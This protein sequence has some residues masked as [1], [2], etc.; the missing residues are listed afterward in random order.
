MVFF[1]LSGYILTSIYD[2]RFY[3]G[4]SAFSY[5]DFLCKRI[6]RIY[7]LH[8]FLLIIMLLVYPR[9]V[10]APDSGLRQVFTN[11]T[12]TQAWSF[13]RFSFIA[14]SWSISVE[15]LFYILFPFFV[16]FMRRNISLFVFLGLGLVYG[17]ENNYWIFFDS[18][19]FSDEIIYILKLTNHNI[20]HYGAFFVMGVC[21]YYF[22][23][24]RIFKKLLEN[25]VAF[26]LLVVIVCVS[27]FLGAAK[28]AIAIFALPLLVRSAHTSSLGSYLLGG[29]VIVWLGELSYAIYLSHQLM[30]YLVLSIAGGQVV[31]PLYEWG[32]TYI[33]I[34]IWSVFCYYCI[35]TVA[36][37]R[38]RNSWFASSK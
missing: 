1:A 6:A 25:N 26:L 31:S 12:L 22:S 11:L 24:W 37:D 21:T 3:S 17:F 30:H 20:F 16:F 33:L 35:E 27:S 15:F 8:F 32:S 10:Y 23:D 36:R 19:K 5:F 28:Y 13:D 38:L 14:A 7:P 2:K 4:V 29:T 9:F 34:I 18:S